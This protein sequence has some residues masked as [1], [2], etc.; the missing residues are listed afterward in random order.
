M[1]L[2]L[3]ETKDNLENKQDVGG[4]GWGSAITFHGRGSELRAKTI[5]CRTMGK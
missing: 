4:R 3:Q 2:I 1:A 5:A